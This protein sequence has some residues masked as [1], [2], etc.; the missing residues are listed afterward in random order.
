MC[1]RDRSVPDSEGNKRKK[2]NEQNSTLSW[3]TMCHFGDVSVQNH[4]LWLY[5][6]GQPIWTKFT[7][8]QEQKTTEKYLQTNPNKNKNV[9]VKT[10]KHTNTTSVLWPFFQDHPGEPVPEDYLRIL[11]CKGR[12][13]EADTQTIWWAPLHPAKQCPPPPS[14]HFFTG[15][16]PFLPPNQ[17][18]QN[19]EGN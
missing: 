4:Q 8:K 19:I 2:Q 9:L 14:H 15:R 10:A 16:M 3:H 11:W 5:H 6:H 18:C 13:S 12:L 7:K 17:H 1:I